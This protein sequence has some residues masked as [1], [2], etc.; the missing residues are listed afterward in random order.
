MEFKILI[1]EEAKRDLN[2]SY[3][4]YRDKV[5][6]KVAQDFFKDFKDSLKIIEM[7]PFFKIWFESYHAKPLTKFPFLIFFLIDKPKKI[8]IIS[9]VFHTSQ[10][11][12]K[13]E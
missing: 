2:F 4:F 9:R 1:S 12:E 13:Y 6:T 5:S 7:N 10:N 8:I 11:P 3:L